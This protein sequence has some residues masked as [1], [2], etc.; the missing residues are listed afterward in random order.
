MDGWMDVKR[1]N[2]RGSGEI[3]NQ[4]IQ[5]VPV[6]K[7][8]RENKEFNLIFR[9]YREAMRYSVSML[10]E[11]YSFSHKMR[12]ELSQSNHVSSTYCSNRFNLLSAL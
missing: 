10:K 11:L 3:N 1:S 4:S 7:N 2:S 9:L 8:F 6:Q 5:R 12:V